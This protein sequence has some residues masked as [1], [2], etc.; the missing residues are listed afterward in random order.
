MTQRQLV[1]AGDHVR[2]GGV[3]AYPTKDGLNI[4]ACY[5]NPNSGYKTV[6]RRQNMN[7]QTDEIAEE[8]SYKLLSAM[9]KNIADGYRV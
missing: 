1:I 9:D 3:I 6:V 7:G 8:I 4:I 5:I 2:S